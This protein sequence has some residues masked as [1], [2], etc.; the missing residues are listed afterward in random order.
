[1][2][3]L[4]NQIPDEEILKIDTEYCSYGDTV[5]YKNPPKIFRACEGSFVYDENNIKFLDLQMWYSACNF[6]YKNERVN[7]ALKEQLDTLPQLASQFINPNKSLL[8]EKLC[9]ANI[10]RFNE[11]GRIHFNVG[12]AQ[13]VDD[14]IKLIRNHSHKSQMFA[15][16]GGYHG[17]TL[18]CSSITSSYRYRRRYGHFGER[19]YFI[20]Y[21][22][23]YRCHYG[24]NKSDCDFYCIKQFEKLFETEYNAILDVKTNEIEFV[25]LFAEPIQGTGGYIIPPKG[26][27]EN[28]KKVLDKYN[29]L[30]ISDEIQ[31]GFYRTGKLWSIEHFNVIPDIITFGKSL[32][33]GINPLSGFWAKEELVNPEKFP[34]GSTHSTFSSNPLGTRAGVEVMTMVEEF[35]YEKLVMEKGKKFLEGLKYIQ[36]KHKNIGDV[37]GLGLALRLEITESDRFTPNKPLT[38]RIAQEGL[39]GQL[40]HKGEKAGLILDIGGHY[41]NVLTLAPSLYISDEEIEMAIE[42]IDKLFLECAY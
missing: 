8:A 2:R 7:N 22:Y 1:M 5:H 9:K 4:V 41:K 12:G 36:S 11:K 20:P 17:R 38:D 32:T 14:A 28:I 30:F 3:L 23:C 15:F 13:A 37:D 21:P 40:N 18:A 16:M 31:M 24:K 26:Y 27:F 29:I 34:P 6:G 10:E 39:T 33:N 35:D 42:L 19:A 25:A